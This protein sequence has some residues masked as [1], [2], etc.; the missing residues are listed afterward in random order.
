MT[1][2][3]LR[4]D[5]TH[6]HVDIAFGDP[7]IDAEGAANVQGDAIGVPARKFQAADGSGG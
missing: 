5:K 6:I 1:L 2:S 7:P 3:T 4:I